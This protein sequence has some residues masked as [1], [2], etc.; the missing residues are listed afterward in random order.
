MMALITSSTESSSQSLLWKISG[1]GLRH[2]SYLYGTMHVQD[3]I[4]HQLGD[5][6][7]PAFHTAQIIGLEVI[8]MEAP[9]NVILIMKSAMMTDHKLSDFLSPDEMELLRIKLDQ[10]LPALNMM[11][12]NIKPFYAYAML[13]E[14][15]LA[16]DKEDVLDLYFEK[17]GIAE[18]KEIWGIETLEEHLSCINRIP[19]GEQIKMLKDY[20]KVSGIIE[21]SG[22]EMDEKLMMRLYQEQNIEKLYEL[23]QASKPSTAFHQALIV[24]RN[25]RMNK[26]LQEAMED[27]KI[28][29]AVGALHL[30]GGQGLIALLRQ[31]GYTVEPVISSYS[32]PSAA[33][34]YQE[35]WM[36]YT[37]KKDMYKIKFPGQAHTG[38]DSIRMYETAAYVSCGFSR[39]RDAK[40]KISYEVLVFPQERPLAPAT[41]LDWLATQNEWKKKDISEQNLPANIAE[42]NLVPGLNKVVKVFFHQKKCYL[43]S[44]MGDSDQLLAVRDLFFDSFHYL[45]SYEE[46]LVPRPAETRP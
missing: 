25:I 23:Y 20:L 21:S 2:S 32:L 28:F 1:N 36:T 31:Q 18:K 17:L 38:L 8:D 16:M 5:S 30:A 19:L 45:S 41:Y 34:M 3:R 33:E 10:Q 24:D 14:E 22:D 15:F 6:V 46:K 29:L 11:I 7:L 39:Y 12:E 35:E 4:A 13:S 9:E 43:L 27:K 44:L 26:R 42:Y 40:N 37:D